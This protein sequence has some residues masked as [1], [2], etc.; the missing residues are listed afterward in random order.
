LSIKQTNSLIN[1]RG[2]RIGRRGEGREGEG[3][4]GEG[5]GEGRREKREKGRGGRRKERRVERIFLRYCVQT[6]DSPPPFSPKYIP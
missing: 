3:R 4:R 1:L 5:K 6:V 2:V